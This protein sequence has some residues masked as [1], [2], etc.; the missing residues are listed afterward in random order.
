MRCS[1]LTFRRSLAGLLVLSAALC[2]PAAQAGTL[3]YNGDWDGRDALTNET[4]HNNG[5]VYDNFVVPAGQ[6]YTLTGAFSNDFARG[7]SRIT[8]AAWEIRSGMSAGNGG[9]L[10]FSGDGA[11]TKTATGRSTNFGGFFVYNEFTMQVSLPSVVLGPGTYW[12]AVIPD[13]TGNGDNVDADSLIST[14]RGPTRSA[15]RPATTTLP[16]SIARTTA[17]PS[18]P[19]PTSKAR[20]RGITRWAL[21]VPFSRTSPHRSPRP[22]CCSSGRHCSWQGI[23]TAAA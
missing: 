17:T 19:R 9:A 3:W 6:T 15:R 8:T 12:L 16:S 10:L 23:A 13:A 20:G 18:R 1:V 7:L 4:G 21:S 11:V 22:W 5:A 2:G 14:T